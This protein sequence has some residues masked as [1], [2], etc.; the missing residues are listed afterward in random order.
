MA[1]ADKKLTDCF[2]F[3]QDQCKKDSA[4]EYRHSQA[5]HDT[6]NVCKFWQ[7]NQC[8][9]PACKFR[10]PSGTNVP[11]LFFAQ[12]KCTKGEACP[13]A[14]I[15]PAAAVD[16]QLLETKKKEADELR[17]LQAERKKEEER[18]ARLKAQREQLELNQKPP[19]VERKVAKERKVAA[20]GTFQRTVGDIVKQDKGKGL[21][22]P[23]K[24]SKPEGKKNKTPE[25]QTKE[26]SGPVSF[27]VKSLEQIRKEK[28]ESPSDKTDVVNA[29]P[30]QPASNSPV[31]SKDS[32]FLEGLRKKNQQKFAAS[33]QNKSGSPS[34]K[35]AIPAISPK[36]Q[37]AEEP[38][39][40]VEQKRQ[41]VVSQEEPEETYE[42]RPFEDSV[43]EDIE[44]DDDALALQEL[45]A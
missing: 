23:Q 3:L 33:T 2:W 25:A 16:T 20:A 39:Q 21:N 29:S 15:S 34:Q 10:H 31:Q 43:V 24:M 45:L 7:Q 11:C 38:T 18:I 1:S 28:T 42:E 22:R 19:I 26:L 44:L 8:T 32:S 9:N 27:G 14:H 40:Q 13:F 30:S 5:A 41:K 36:R 37:L 17:K 35:T 6:Q 4:C 12:G